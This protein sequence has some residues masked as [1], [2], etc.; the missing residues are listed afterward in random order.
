MSVM[1]SILWFVIAIGV[2]VTVHEFGHFWVA[3]RLGVKVLRFSIGFG[4]PLW[5]TRAGRDDVEYVIGA[6]PLGGYVKM[7]D[8]SEGDV[9]ASQVHRAFNRQSLP[10][11]F[12]VVSAGPVFNF[13]FAV[14][15]YW[16]MFIIGVAGLKPL[17]GEVAPNSLASAAGFKP[18]QEITRVAD[19]ETRSWEGVIQGIIGGSLAREPVSVQVTDPS[20]GIETLSIDL[21]QVALDDLTRGQFFERLGLSPMRP[22]VPPR[23]GKVFEGK[24]A[25][26]A[27][28]RQ[29]DLVIAVDGLPIETWSQLV[30][31]LRARPEQSIQVV[32]D[33]SG[34]RQQLTLIPRAEEEN[35]EKVGKIDAALD[36]S[37]REQYYGVER[38]S[39]VEAL[40]RA[41][42]K[43]GQI[44]ALTLQM[45][46]KMVTL[47]VSVENLS[48]PISIAQ[49]A[50]V[51][52]EV[53]VARFLEFLAI[54]SI[55]LGIINL[56]PIPLLDGG[57]LMYYLIEL[58][59]G[60]PVSEAVQFVAQRLGIA[61]LVC[62]M[63]LAF[64]NDLARIF[65]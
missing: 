32:V 55:S 57:H 59:Q 48:G 15:A 5:R 35:G 65:G 26:K 63:G 34:Q 38:Y 51:S 33:R 25:D 31:Y 53:G 41:L 61:M 23:F 30:D 44:T 58:V 29:G 64:Y 49:Y 7:L 8:E 37:V 54:V 36:E 47:E 28:L 21:S 19:R 2:L 10:V 12:A 6:I 39:V 20:R 50:G 62:L 40:G 3:R 24:P 45:L 43:T 11:R 56:L 46:W 9:P 16:A 4:R 1:S 27:G 42:D 22:K 60:R 14:I 18:G 52:A 17:V 13:L